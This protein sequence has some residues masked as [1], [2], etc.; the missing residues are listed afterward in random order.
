MKAT[1]RAARRI[2]S[3]TAAPCTGGT[4]SALSF[5]RN[6]GW[7]VDKVLHHNPVDWNS[8]ADEFKKACELAEERGEY[9]FI[10]VEEDRAMHHGSDKMP[11]T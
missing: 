1:G 7:R 11:R 6:E 10:S 5:V 4:E 9:L 3:W 2:F 8:V